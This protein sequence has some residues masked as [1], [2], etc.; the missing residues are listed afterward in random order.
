MFRKRRGSRPPAEGDGK[1]SGLNDDKPKLEKG[2]LPAMLIAAFG[3]FL[4]AAIIV[5]VFIVGILW[6]F[7][8]R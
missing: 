5:T 8:F 4:P 2:D 7:F 1:P 3:V 6:F